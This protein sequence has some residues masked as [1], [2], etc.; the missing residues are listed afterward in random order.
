M[1]M[2]GTSFREVGDESRPDFF[3]W[4]FDL[5]D[6]RPGKIWQGYFTY[7]LESIQ[8]STDAIRLSDLDL[9]DVVPLYSKFVLDSVHSG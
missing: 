2:G 7:L 4:F 8:F 1:A 3:A 5:S 6:L 9:P